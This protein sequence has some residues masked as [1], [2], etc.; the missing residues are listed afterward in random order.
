MYFTRH[1]LSILSLFSIANSAAVPDAGRS[2]TLSSREDTS[3][4]DECTK[5]VQA[6]VA[7]SI[8]AI[9]RLGW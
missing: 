5:Q 1:L 7:G 6:C 3:C 8:N 2:G 4:Q 9:A